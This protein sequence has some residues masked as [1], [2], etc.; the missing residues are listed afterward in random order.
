M[1]LIKSV[2]F[3]AAAILTVHYVPTFLKNSFVDAQ[4]NKKTGSEIVDA[5]I[6]GYEE[7][8]DPGKF[9]VITA[10]DT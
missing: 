3:L 9:R 7:S 8:D 10:N 5:I 6:T 2:A 1:K 4:T